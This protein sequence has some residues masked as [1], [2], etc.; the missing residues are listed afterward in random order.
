[1][2]KDAD[3]LVEA[4]DV[5]GV[6]T[7]RLQGVH[8]PGEL[9]NRIFFR[10]HPELDGRKLE[11]HETGLV[12][13]WNEILSRIVEPLLMAGAHGMP[14]QGE[15]VLPALRAKFP[16]WAVVSP[17][18]YPP[19][20]ARAIRSTNTAS[21]GS[22][23]VIHCTGGGP[24]K[25]S[26][27]SGFNVSAVDY[28]LDFYLSKGAPHAH[29]VIDFNGAVYACKSEDQEAAHAGWTALGGSTFW[30]ERWTAPAWW[31]QAWPDAAS[32]K[33]LLPDSDIR[34]PNQHSIGVE[35]LITDRDAKFYTADQYRGLA[36]LLAEVSRR[37]GIPLAG[38][39]CRRLLGHEDVHPITDGQYPGIDG[40]ANLGG[41]WDPGGHR[42]RPYFDWDALWRLLQPMLA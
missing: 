35:L 3:M 10:R 9:A 15:T 19:P 31:K 11:L 8:A 21:R 16:E 2:P 32:P 36:R 33:D 17:L 23:F 29:Y 26:R 37:R 40:R 5:L 6:R 7:L 18:A 30:T 38:A 12:Q 14:P 34:Y 13:E 24:A 42:N 25:R 27:A 28:A 20:E 4:G 41:G 39:P 22:W 1:M